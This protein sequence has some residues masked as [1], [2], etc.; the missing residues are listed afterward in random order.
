M[1]RIADRNASGDRSD[2]ADAASAGRG[3]R[4][5]RWVITAARSSSFSALWEIFGRDINPV[6]GSYPSAIAVAFVDLAAHRQA[7]RGDGAKACSHSSSA[8]ASPS[9]SACRSDS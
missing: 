5:P 6:F 2:D 3:A 9:C 8:M 1:A 4:V 7:R